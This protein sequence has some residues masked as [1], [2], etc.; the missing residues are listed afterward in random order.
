VWILFWVIIG[1]ICFIGLVILFL[2]IPFDLILAFDTAAEKKLRVRLTWLF[3]LIGRE[4]S[5]SGKKPEPPLR[6][7]RTRIRRRINIST[8][9]RVLNTQG[10]LTA[11]FNLNKRI[12][13]KIQ[14]REVSADLTIGFEDPA[15]GGMVFACVGMLRPFIPSSGRYSL[16]IQPQFSDRSFILGHLRSVLRLQPAGLIIPMGRFIFS[17]P[18]L[19]VFRMIIADFKSES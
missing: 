13:R 17:R 6:V 10:F 2:C 3:G 8:V 14:I 7:R 9:W 15:D 16:E 19:K 1:L 4:F 18:T 12:L 5:L 11:I